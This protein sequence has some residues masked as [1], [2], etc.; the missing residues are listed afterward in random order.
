MES[1]YSVGVS[2]RFS[3]FYE[4]D[5]NPGDA[6]ELAAKDTREKLSVKEE[7][8]PTVITAGGKS[9]DNNKD[10]HQATES[11]SGSKKTP[12]SEVT[13]KGINLVR[14]VCAAP[15]PCMTGGQAKGEKT[16]FSRNNEQ[17]GRR[18]DGPQSNK[19]GT[20]NKTSRFGEQRR[21][22]PPPREKDEV[23]QSGNVGSRDDK[24]ANFRE[25]RINSRGSGSNRGRGRGAFR[26]KR[27]F[28]R[29]SGSDR[30]YALVHLR[31]D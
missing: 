2:N 12:T 17:D 1:H 31:S 22:R 11:Q 15:D 26:G 20:V 21:N 5:D 28:D 23:F 30:R 3:L 24:P 25:G 27:E 29:R 8:K 18:R 19:D 14:C 13:S 7:K 16:R 4:D 6:V 9:K 10:K